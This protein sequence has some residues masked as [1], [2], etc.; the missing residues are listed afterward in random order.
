MKDTKA[1]SI[2]KA[3]EVLKEYSN[4]HNNFEIVNIVNERKDLVHILIKSQRNNALS[5]DL[6]APFVFSFLHVG[7]LCFMFDEIRVNDD[8]ISLYK[9]S[10]HL[11]ILYSTRIQ[12]SREE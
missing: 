3:L 8:G 5:L 6:N 4:E 12:T 10:K 7:G 11:V 9:D 2:K 1:R